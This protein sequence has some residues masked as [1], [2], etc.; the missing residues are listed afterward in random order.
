MSESSTCS[1]LR[2]SFF[3]VDPCSSVVK[4]SPRN[5]SSARRPARSQLSRAS[6][7]HAGCTP[8]RNGSDG[9]PGVMSSRARV[10]SQEP[11]QCGA[12]LLQRGAGVCR[13]GEILGLR[14]IRGD[15]VQF[16][17]FRGVADVDHLVF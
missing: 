3:R 17:V 10:T 9:R 4:T 7:L 1:A 15:V 12:E 2:P 14:R 8:H 13:A 6:H 5:L 16:L 11:V